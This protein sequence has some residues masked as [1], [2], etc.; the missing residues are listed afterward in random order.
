MLGDRDLR[1]GRWPR[2]RWGRA[3]GV[4]SDLASGE[5]VADRYSTDRMSLL[6]ERWTV[7]Y[8]DG[9]PR[10][11]R[12]PHAW[13]QDVAIEWEG[14]ARYRTMLEVPRT[15]GLLRFRGVSYACRVTVD[16]ED[17]AAHEGMWDAFDVDLSPYARRTVE[18][19]VDVVKNGG[20]L[21]PVGS[22]LSG[23]LPYLH[24]T[25]GGIYR[26]VE[27]VPTG[28]PLDG[29]VLVPRL[30]V[31]GS[32]LRL[33]GAPFYPRGVLHWGW[34]PEG[35]GPHPTEEEARREIA[36]VAALGFN[37]V[38]FSLWLPPHR[39]LDALE[40]AGLA[41]WIE[42]PL[43]QAKPALFEDPRIEEELERI[44]RQYRGHRCV[45]AWTVGCEMGNAPA[46]F[47]ARMVAKVQALTGC[48]L[49][50]DSSGGAEMY[51]GDPREFGTF[52]DFHP[53]AD[54]PVYGHL[55]DSL[56]LGTRAGTPML[57]G[58]TMDADAHRDLPRVARKLPPW[59]S[60]IGELN[61]PGV[62]IRDELSRLARELPVF[63]DE[64]AERDAELR[65][66]AAERAA[67][68]RRTM[69]EAARAR[70]AVSGYV[71]TALRD[72]PIT[73]S[74]I[75]DDWGGQRFTTEDVRGWNAPSML[76]MSPL[77]RTPLRSGGNVPRA[78]DPL[79]VAPGTATWRIGGHSER[80][81]SGRLLW[82]ILDL[83]EP[84]VRR[85]AAEGVGEAAELPPL[86]PRE[87][88]EIHWPVTEPGLY[89]LEAEFAGV[90]AGWNLVVADTAPYLGANGEP[91]PAGAPDASERDDLGT[92]PL[93]RGWDARA[94]RAFAGGE[95][96][97]VQIDWG[98]AAGPTVGVPFWRECA[99]LFDGVAPGFE[100]VRRPE[101][102]M[103]VSV[104]RALD[105]AAWRRRLGEVVPLVRRVDLRSYRQDAY[106]F[107]AR[108]LVV[109]TLPLEERADEPFTPLSAS[110][111]LYRGWFEAVL[112]GESRRESGPGG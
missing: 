38:K 12:V 71:V 6:I 75:F 104:R 14:P 73:T 101:T 19:R 107:R 43:W 82:R 54:L 23:F 17:A 30:E 3:F 25:W 64:G 9:G 5:L 34:Y 22:V 94:D 18:V 76:F 72:T 31:E 44:V 45:V 59:A 83:R 27:L 47:R 58:E 112:R 84:G 24:Q 105:L 33:D 89:R 8:G 108:N 57:L 97:I 77:R 10:E 63:G 53:C 67:F 93:Y 87:L 61:A 62:R 90:S 109:T 41:A 106:A 69:A 66:D 21:H 1:L 29:D 88:L 103:G 36:R 91:P 51:G 100:A 49:V 74:G 81:L 48:P 70:P 78:L 68:V 40:E 46:A 102:Q 37:L 32:R 26:E 52:E 20:R 56:A 96:A 16:G 60:S 95:R 50:R 86:A 42:L 80:G 28:T 55:L 79:C 7:E 15:G 110:P 13:G 4:A 2:T 65:R 35:G 98:D 92:L 39:Y 85:V 11:V 111:A 99:L